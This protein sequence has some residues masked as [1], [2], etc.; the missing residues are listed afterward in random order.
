MIV[1]RLG[2]R[3][4]LLLTA[5]LLFIPLVL[6]AGA[7]FFE[8]SE[9]WFHMLEHL[10]PRYLWQSLILALGV[11]LL[12]GVMGV[13]SAWIF[14]RFSFPFKRT[15]EVLSYL[16]LSIPAYI[17]AYVF[18]EFF[19]Y[20]P[21]Q[22]MGGLILVMSLALFPYVFSAARSSF[23]YQ[24]DHFLEAA[25]SLGVGRRQAFWKIA[26]PLARP[27][28]AAG[29]SLVLMETLAEYGAAKYYGVENFTTG[30]FRAYHDYWS[31]QP[32]LA[33]KLSGILLLFSFL[34]LGIERRSRGRRGYSVQIRGGQDSQAQPKLRGLRWLGNMMVVLF[35][36][37]LG[38]LLPLGLIIAWGAPNLVEALPKLLG[39]LGNTLGLGV[40]AAL[41]IL[42][43]AVLFV[44]GK[45]V[46]GQKS[47]LGL[48][49][50]FSTMG[51]AIPGAVVA[52]SVSV[53]VNAPILALFRAGWLDV[54]TGRGL[55]LASGAFA[56]VFAYGVRYLSVGYRPLDGHY[57]N[58]GNRL[59]EASL[60]LGKSPLRTL[61]QVNFPLLKRALIT[62]GL[63]VFIDVI[64]ELPLT[65]ILRPANLE[66]LA[67]QAF[68][69]A[70][71]SELRSAMPYSFFIVLLG[72][73]PTLILAFLRRKPVRAPGSPQGKQKNPPAPKE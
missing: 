59:A 62:A 12:A 44:H 9:D 47:P 33:L 20:L 28:L 25:Q 66:T 22:S 14:S 73:I 18:A 36:I 10:I 51:Y 71:I 58:L 67:L 37:V 38:F 41:I 39:P 52:L 70:D 2:W 60:S 34:L 17:L 61:F 6:I 11:G 13:W 40:L 5:L 65:L 54:Q 3:L 19:D 46:V 48:M 49:T 57:A 7:T 68:Y 21:I 8:W 24:S 43:V 56:L 69:Y 29:I 27:A 35:P 64:K 32:F 23:S 55:M 15:M 26:L 30:I 31:D 42:A 16:P 50:R 53:V 45:M 72:L 4:S 1:K 63:L